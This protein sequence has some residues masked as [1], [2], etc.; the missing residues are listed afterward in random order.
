MWLCQRL[1]ESLSLCLSS[2]A[3]KAVPNDI[4]VEGRHAYV[5]QDKDSTS[6]RTPAIEYFNRSTAWGAEMGW[7]GESCYHLAVS[8]SLPVAVFS[9]VWTQ[10]P[11]T[12]A[13]KCSLRQ[14]CPALARWL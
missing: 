5:L 3:A 14:V 6:L 11:R 4:H 12:R 10:I 2:T 13:Q 9:I 7:W 8:L 1:H